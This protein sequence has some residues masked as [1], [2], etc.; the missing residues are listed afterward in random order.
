MKQ[1]THFQKYP[2]ILYRQSNTI[3]I[4][5]STRYFRNLVD[6]FTQMIYLTNYKYLNKVFRAIFMDKV[7]FI[8]NPLLIMDILK[9]TPAHT[10]CTLVV[11]S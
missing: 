9:I 10:T 7:K 4:Y 1:V 3:I 2:K 5:K 8:Y 6:L 11:R